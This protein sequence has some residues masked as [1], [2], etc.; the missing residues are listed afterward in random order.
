MTLKKSEKLTEEQRVKLATKELKEVLER[1]HVDLISEFN[2][3][4]W[5]EIRQYPK[6]H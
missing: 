6:L 3:E 4:A 2:Q 1:Y 5:I